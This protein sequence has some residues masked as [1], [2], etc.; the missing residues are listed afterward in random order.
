MIRIRRPKQ[1]SPLVRE[2]AQQS[3]NISERTMLTSLD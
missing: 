2:V 3:F 1:R